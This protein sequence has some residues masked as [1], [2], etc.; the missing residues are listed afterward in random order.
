MTQSS[1]SRH[2]G[3]PSMRVEHG[4]AVAS[5]LAEPRLN[6]IIRL[7]AGHDGQD[8][9]LNHPRVQKPGLALAGHTHG[10][11]PTR[12]QI[13]GETEITFLEGLPPQEQLERVRVLFGLGLSLVVVTRGIEPPAALIEVAEATSTPLAVAEPRSSRAIHAI[14]LVL[15]GVLA[16]SETRHGVLMDVHGIGTLLLGPSGI[17]KSE[18]ALFLVERGHRFVADDQVILSLLP[19]EQILGR[20]PTLLR[21]HLE[22]RGIGIIN[23]RDLFGANAVRSEKTVQLVVEICPWSDDEPFERLGLDDATVE[24]LGVPIPMLRIPVRPGRNMAVILEVAARNHILKAAGHHGAQKFINTL[25]DDVED[26]S[27]GNAR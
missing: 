19:S 6:A 26:P 1:S 4:I 8:R 18:C 2:G 23:V 25:M 9:T 14:H 13:L 12:V 22:V 7:V 27:A 21:N 15:D 16:P 20:A 17:G 10:V 3:L 11:V 5:L 24:I